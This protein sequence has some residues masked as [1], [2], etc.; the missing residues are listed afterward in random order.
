MAQKIVKCKVCG[1]AYYYAKHEYELCPNCL[2]HKRPQ[3]FPHGYVYT[4]VYDA[5]C[6]ICKKVY[7]ATAYTRTCKQCRKSACYATIVIRSHR[8]H[9]QNV[10]G[11]WYYM[12][13]PDA[14]WYKKPKA[15]K[16]KIPKRPRIYGL[17]R[18]YDKECPI[19]KSEYRGSGY[20]RLCLRCRK[21]QAGYH[22]YVWSM[23]RQYYDPHAAWHLISGVDFDSGHKRRYLKK[24]RKDECPNCK[25][26]YHPTHNFPA[27]PRCRK[28]KSYHLM[29]V[30]RWKHQAQNPYLAWRQCC[31]WLR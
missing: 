30:R 22:V 24:K 20:Q 21:S 17:Y 3:K 27:C 23:R 7:R 12:S 28:S 1:A 19:C 25:M 14:P 8:M 18:Y 5:K 2:L 26:Y 6:I 9:A 16:I 10:R 11:V 29:L 4:D 31:K 15:P 13:G